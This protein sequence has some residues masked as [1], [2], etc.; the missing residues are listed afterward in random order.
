M[1]VWEFSTQK[2][3]QVSLRGSKTFHKADISVAYWKS[4]LVKQTKAKGCSRQPIRIFLIAGDRDLSMIPR[5]HY[6]TFSQ[7]VSRRAT[8]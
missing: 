8:K 3:T 6:S 4:E 2:C 1:A 7:L 5:M